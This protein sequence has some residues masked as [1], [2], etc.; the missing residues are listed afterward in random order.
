VARWPAGPAALVALVLAGCS[1]TPKPAAPIPAPAPAPEPVV[2]PAPPA[3][4]M[5]PSAAAGAYSLRVEIQ[6][7]NRPQP[8]NPRAPQ[9]VM[10]LARTAARTRT[11]AGPAT[12][13]GATIFI[14]GYTRPV[15]RG[16][17][18]PAAWWPVGGDSLVIQFT[19]GQQSRGEIQLRGAVHGPRVAG[20]VWYV[21]NE[22]GS[23]F[24]LGTFTGSRTR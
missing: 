17:A 20:E 2:A 7:G 3:E 14:P 21:S 5:A 9:P 19:Q 12:Q 16:N 18:Q 13:Y 11:T 10:T 8:R 6:S 24:Q 4:A 1:S 23:T 22:T 15:R